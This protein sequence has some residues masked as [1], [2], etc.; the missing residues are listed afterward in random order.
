MPQYSDDVLF[1][2]EGQNLGH[3]DARPDAFLRNLDISGVLSGAFEG[4]SIFNLGQEVIPFASNPVFDATADS[5]FIITLTGNVA[6]S[7]LVNHKRGQLVAFVIKQ[8]ATGGRTFVWPTNTR[9]GMDIGTG[10][11]ETS[12]QLFISDGTL[13]YGFM[14][15]IF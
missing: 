1:E 8:D 2:S 13:L 6:S 5:S 12:V 15:A 7:T 10:V 9:G 14:G 11:N 4:A 3:P